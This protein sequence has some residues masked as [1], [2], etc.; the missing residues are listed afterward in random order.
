MSA[1]K[2]KALKQWEEH[3]QSVQQATTASIGESPVDVEERIKRARRD[4]AFFVEHYFPHYAKS[5]T[6]KFQIKAANKVLKSKKIRGLFEWARGHAKST[7]FTIFI[8]M[9]LMIQEDREINF[10]LVIGKSEKSAHK[11]LGDL[12][13]ELQYNHRF[14]KDN[15]KQYNAGSWEDGQFTTKQGI[16]FM[17]LGRGQSPRGIR[18]RQNRP[19]YIVFDD[20]DD[21]QMCRNEDRVNK[22]FDW[23]ME[24][25]LGAMDM[26]RGRFIGVGNRIHKKS[27]IAKFA[28]LKG[29]YHTVVNALNKDGQPTWTEKYTLDEINEQIAL[30]GYRRSQ[31]EYFNNPVEEGTIFKGQWINW[32]KIPKLDTMDG[33]VLYGDPSF[34]DGTKNDYKAVRLWAIK[35]SRLY[36]LRSFVR[37]TTVT[38]MV[39][40]YYDVHQSLPEGVSCQYWMEANFLQDMLLEQFKVE[41]EIR[42]YQLPIRGDK[43][44]KPNKFAR[45]ENLSPYY[46]RGVITYD[47]KLKEDEDT[48]T[49]LEQ[50]LAFEKGSK[51]H[52]DCPD[53]DEGAIYML[54]KN[55]RTTDFVPV[56]GERK[57]S[58]SW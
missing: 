45:I 43:R 25:V 52:D 40:F 28:G 5:K 10:M 6:A 37:Q 56:Y 8:P 18:D 2:S 41:G 46:E 15:G 50:L 12:Q 42:G 16:A 29:I 23:L 17:A 27:I 20:I 7:H 3:C 44:K 19:D 14:I 35:G 26:G 9:W 24:A 38:N 34:K 13:A 48:K 54:Q 1:T 58:R 30:M 36:L 57:H 21:D 33:L 53:A 11:L 51:V 39:S 47:E 55:T 49:G 22:V 4:Y 32:G 31:K